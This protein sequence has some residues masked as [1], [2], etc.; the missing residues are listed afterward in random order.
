MA[1]AYPRIR[2]DDAPAWAQPVERLVVDGV[3]SE[4]V[5]LNVSGRELTGPMRGFGQ[6]WRKTY[7]ARL[8]G[9]SPREVMAAWKQNFQR[10]WPQGNHF[11]AA[12]E[13]IR[14]GNVAVLNLMQPRLGPP[15]ISTGVYVIYADE[16]SFSFMTP[17]GHM[18]AGLITFSAFAEGDHTVAQVQAFVRASDPLYELSLRLQFGHRIEDAF[19]KD[20]LTNLA[21]HFRQSV[22]VGK[23]VTCLDP[24]LQWREAR[25]VWQNAAVRTGLYAMS[26]VFRRGIRRL[27]RM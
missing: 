13:G 4:A 18:F 12:V 25:N 11:Y 14:P 10:F 2:S 9:A 17:Q 8:R 16:E 20:T 1:L 26:A 7:Q 3:P 23:A 6:L 22:N 21:A 15:L 27:Q 5:N 24:R 19:W